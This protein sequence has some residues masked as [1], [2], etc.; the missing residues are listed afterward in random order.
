MLRTRLCDLLAIDHPVISA[1]MAGTA[2]ADLAVAVSEAGGLGMLGVPGSESPE[3]LRDQIQKVRTHTNR[4]FGVGFISSLP[5]IDAL[6]EVALDERVPVIS[7]SFGDPTPYVAPAQ[8][9]GIKVI[10][11]V[12]KVAQA[13]TAAAAGV[14]VI[15]A[16]G[17]EA[18]GHT[19]H[20]G[21]L[22]LVP[23]VV[24]AAG[25]IPVVA[26]GGIADGRGLAAALILG[27]EG[28]WLGS[29]FAVSHESVDPQWKKER[30]VQAGTDDTLLTKVYDLALDMPFPAEI[31]DRVLANDFVREW[32]GRNEEILARR[33]SLNSLLHNAAS[34]GDERIAAVRLGNA[35][36]L[37]SSVEPAGDILRRI[38]QE[39]EALLL[40]R[41][42]HLLTGS[43]E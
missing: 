42:Q 25:G 1:P 12:Q 14:D 17:T 27:A 30:G 24:D 20:S 2:T 32:H 18:G 35:V 41:P 26:A 5:N 19:G 37:I 8:S 7:H 36:G 40:E 28:A 13:K 29:R 33:E 10:A 38:V 3:W 21:T 9:L 23:A 43:W 4:P 15:T 11:Q 31:A 39:A 16:Q 22:S 34:R 6:H